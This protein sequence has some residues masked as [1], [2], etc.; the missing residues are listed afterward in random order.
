MRKFVLMSA[1]IALSIGAAMSLPGDEAAAQSASAY[2]SAVDVVVIPSELPKYL[3]AIKENGAA[4]VKEPG[5][6]AFNIAL[7]ANNPNHVVLYEVY[8]SEAAAQAHRETDHFKKYVAT[9]SS[10][11]A[12]RTIRV[13]SPVALNSKAP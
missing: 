3:E 13:L 8:D 1:A 2:I 9:T 10:M 4:S 11:I 7:L 6:R 12:E 5:C